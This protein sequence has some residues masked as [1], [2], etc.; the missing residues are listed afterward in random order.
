MSRKK[1]KAKVKGAKERARF[2][3]GWAKAPDGCFN[4]HA[5]AAR[6]AHAKQCP[7]G[8][9]FRVG[10]ARRRAHSP[11]K[12]GAYTPL[13]AHPTGLFDIVSFEGGEFAVVGVAVA[14]TAGEGGF[15]RHFMLLKP[16]AADIDL[17]SI[18]PIK[19]GRTWG[20]A[21]WQQTATRAT[22]PAVMVRSQESC[23][24]R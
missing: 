15:R 20:V 19:R 23:P 8:T 17:P 21:A 6:P 4:R 22:G 18:R 9:A 7:R 11:V 1:Q 14:A 5:G 24:T 2:F 3:V 13:M 12:E 10:T 16:W